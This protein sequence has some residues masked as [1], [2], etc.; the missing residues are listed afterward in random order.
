MGDIKM[1][2]RLHADFKKIK[3]EGFGYKIFGPKNTP[4]FSIGPYFVK[5]ERIKWEWGG[6]NDGFCFFTSKK[7]ALRLLKK[8]KGIRSSF[9][10]GY[11]NH[12][13]CKIKYSGGIGKHEED[14]IITGET[15]ITAICKE[16]KILEQVTK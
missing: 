3:S 15:Y 6:I 11:I 7:E 4:C 16:F 5:E 1:C 8:L 10:E 12:Y 9:D 13:I 2:N 14:N